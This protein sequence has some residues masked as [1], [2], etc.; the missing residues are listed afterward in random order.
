MKKKVFIT[1]RLPEEWIHSLRDEFEVDMYEQEEHPITR[2]ELLSRVEGVHGILCLL[3]ESMD[4]SVIEAAGDNLQVI[5]N[6]AV[7][8]DNIDISAATQKGIFVTNTPDVLTE[9][10]ADL[11]FA[12]LLATARRLPEAER[13]LRTGAWKSWSPLQ[14]TGLDVYGKRLGIVGLGRIGA[15]VA[16]RA[17]GF[18]MDVVYSSRSVKGEL[19]RELGLCR[20]EFTELL[21]TSD[22]V[23]L[24]VPGTRDTAAMIGAGE[25]ALMKPTSILINGARGSVVDESALIDALKHRRIYAA[26]L[27]VFTHEPLSPRH[28]LCELDNVVLLPHI[29][30]ASVET[31]RR[32][33]GRAIENLTAA[34]RGEQPPH[35]V[36]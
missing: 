26:G 4:S 21:Q 24:T 15:A 16:K 11:L 14:L 27:D 6:V 9:T 25:L 32:M 31:R 36:R 13:Y 5:S 23:V 33:A 8:W 7:G 20:V 18:S 19:E 1:R 28:P 10:T 3:T 29:G 2:A 30:S 22:F 17:G 12:L 34:L 35:V